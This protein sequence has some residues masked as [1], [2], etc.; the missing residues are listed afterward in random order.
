MSNNNI[1]LP[2]EMVEQIRKE[3][4]FNS[5]YSRDEDSNPFRNGYYSGFIS[6]ATEYA[7]KLQEARELIEKM[8]ERCKGLY[9]DELANK[10]KMFLYGE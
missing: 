2:V 7:T 3:A 8:N 4:A 1:Q 10:I 9:H 5:G 6:G